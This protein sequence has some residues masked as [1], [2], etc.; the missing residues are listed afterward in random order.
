MSPYAA[1]VGVAAVILVLGGMDQFVVSGWAR[2]VV[3]SCRIRWRR[4]SGPAVPGYD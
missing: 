3:S 1:R 2:V 4:C